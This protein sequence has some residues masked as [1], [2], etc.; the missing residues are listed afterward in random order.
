MI[1]V[2]ANFEGTTRRMKMPLRDMV[3]GVLESN[4]CGEIFP[5]LPSTQYSGFSGSIKKVVMAL[6]NFANRSELS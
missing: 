5:I 2:K 3:P 6:P 4:V 1:T